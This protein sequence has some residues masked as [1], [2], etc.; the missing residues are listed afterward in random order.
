MPTFATESSLK[1]FNGPSDFSDFFF[2]FR[3]HILPPSP[4][5]ALLHL[6]ISLKC[7]KTFHFF[8]FFFF[9]FLSFLIICLYLLIVDVEIFLTLNEFKVSIFIQT[10]F[11]KWMKN[12]LKSLLTCIDVKCISARN[13]RFRPT[14]DGAAKYP[15][16]VD[17]VWEKER[18]LTKKS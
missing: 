8:F 10:N 17:W 6:C 13:C 11:M 2:F 18:K 16:T 15:N 14:L 12:V 7:F 4:V 3:I 9:S 5:A 1:R